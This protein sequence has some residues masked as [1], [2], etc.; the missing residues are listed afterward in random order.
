MPDLM[1]CLPVSIRGSPARS[2]VSSEELWFLGPLGGRRGREREREIERER[3]REREREGERERRVRRGRKKEK[4]RMGGRENE[5]FE[6][7]GRKKE[8]SRQTEIEGEREEDREVSS[9]RNK[10]GES[11]IGRVRGGGV[12]EEDRMKENRRRTERQIG[13]WYRRGRHR[14]RGEIENRI[15]E[16]VR[17]IQRK[18]AE[19]S[20]E[21]MRMGQ[22][23]NMS[24]AK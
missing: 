11:E 14:R 3:E 24:I 12:E 18:I 8:N 1:V 5:K 6:V 16:G 10:E 2:L 17:A 13:R 15:R 21:L 20:S 22:R 4:E 19:F 9:G 7:G 23:H